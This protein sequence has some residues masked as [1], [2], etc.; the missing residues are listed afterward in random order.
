MLGPGSFP[1]PQA[2]YQ[3]GRSLWARCGLAALPKKLTEMRQS[4]FFQ[5]L[6]NSPDRAR[7]RTEDGESWSARKV[8]RRLVG[9]RLV[10]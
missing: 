5:D 10:H 6:G 7:V 4:R 1:G 9:H 2:A 3:R 8:L